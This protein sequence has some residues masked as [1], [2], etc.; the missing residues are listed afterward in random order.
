MSIYFYLMDGVSGI[1]AERYLD[2]VDVQVHKKNNINFT[3]MYGYDCTLFSYTSLLSG[4]NPLAF[5]VINFRN[6][7]YFQSK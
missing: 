2:S 4:L 5:N 6:S 7:K 1:E 3:M